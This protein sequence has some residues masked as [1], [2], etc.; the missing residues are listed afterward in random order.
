MADAGV[1]IIANVIIQNFERY[2]PYQEGFLPIL[3]K[4]GG[5]L[6]AVDDVTQ[7]LEGSAPLSGRVVILKFPSESAADAWFNDPDYQALSEHR[8]AG[9]LLNFITLVHPLERKG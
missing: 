7:T 8:R 3:K 2:R 1:Y 6:I 4:H 5:T 9:T